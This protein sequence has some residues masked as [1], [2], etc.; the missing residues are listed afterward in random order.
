M[1]NAREEAILAGL[2]QKYSKKQ[3]IALAAKTVRP[4]PVSTPVVDDGPFK[5]NLDAFKPN[6]DLLTN[7]T[8]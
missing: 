8:L 7:R 2:R 6:L 1:H 4:Q 3:T 5:P